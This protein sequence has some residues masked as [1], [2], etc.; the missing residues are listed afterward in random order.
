MKRAIPADWFSN[1]ENLQHFKHLIKLKDKELEQKFDPQQSVRDL[2]RQKSDFLDEILITSWR[3]FLG[4]N[5]E[6][7]NA[8]ALAVITFKRSR[9]PI[10]LVLF[11]SILS[12]FCKCHKTTG[13]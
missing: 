3:H 9:R 10:F 1:K 11:S 6:M 7:V 5:A 2:L 8:P 4:K 12:S 13:G